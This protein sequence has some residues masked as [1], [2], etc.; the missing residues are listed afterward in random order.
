[1][2]RADA[3]KMQIKTSKNPCICLF[4]F[5]KIGTFQGVAAEKMKKS[6]SLSTRVS[7]CGRGPLFTPVGHP[8]PSS[9]DLKFYSI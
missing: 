2:G 7:G 6:G 1:M 4:F 3:K 9:A 8:V 5:G